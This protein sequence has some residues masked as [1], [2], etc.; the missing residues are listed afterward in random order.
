MAQSSDSADVDLRPRTAADPGR[1]RPTARLPAGSGAS[2]SRRA[3]PHNAPPPGRRSGGAGPERPGSVRQSALAITVLGP[4]RVAVG[5]VEIHLKTR[6]ARAVLAYLALSSSGRETRERLVGL[7]WSETAEDK[8]RASLRQTLHELREAFSAAGYSGLATARQLLALDASTVV[9]DVAT[10][11]SGVEDGQVD[12]LLTR[13]DL[14]ESFLQDLEEVDPAF[15]QWAKA[16]RQTVHEAFLRRLEDGLRRTDAAPAD[17]RRLCEGL[18]AIEPTNEEACRSVMRGLAVD[19]D[20]AGALRAYER[21]WRL[22]DEDYD[23]EPSKP[24]QDLVAEI[25]L[26]KFDQHPAS[27]PSDALLP[28]EAAR[29]T[30]A[31]IIERFLLQSVETAQSHLVEG[32]RRDL[33]ACLV[34]FR[35]WS[36]L[37]GSPGGVAAA[38]SRGPGRYQLAAAAGQIGKIVHLALTLREVDTHVYVWS[39][40]IELTLDNWFEAQQRIVRRIAMTLNVQVSAERL[41]RLS[42]EPDVSLQVYDKWLRGQSMISRFDPDLW[43]RAGQL[44]SE[45]ATEA[46][47]FSLA[48]SSLAEMNNSVH[49]AHPG[50]F[51]DPAKARSTLDIARRAVAIDPTHSRTHLCLGWSYAMAK[52]FPQAA[53]HMDLAS[54]LNPNESWTLMSTALFNAFYGEFA[55]ARDM[56]AQSL[57]MSLTPT[58]THWA[59]QVSILF[60]AGDYEGA[61]FAADHAQDVIRTLPAW[62]AAA[63]F[64]LGCQ[65]EAC[66][67]AAR[68]IAG[69]RSRWFGGP[70]PDDAAIGRWL[71]HLYPIRDPGT[72]ESLRAGVVGAGIPDAGLRHNAW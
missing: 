67:A 65:D 8:A 46:P 64:H 10:I 24:T 63:L 33:I 9:V 68:F 16:K 23:A 51:R 61:I 28:S 54:D 56:A 22:L 1:A 26:G 20:V 36:V 71:L 19:G 60:L 14:T 4:F 2:Q 72:W 43:S 12:P 70:P 13:P 37:E 29:T 50:V 30:I 40:R 17:R 42:G 6:K 5:G 53:V 58:S 3:L 59:Y 66:T 21:L 25:K 11:L 62:R 27:T 32:F 18:L 47:N 39:D 48:F 35:E 31:I 7:L 57:D 52:Q 49:I 38:G 55:R 34:R 44:F 15:G 45:A 69:I 41:A